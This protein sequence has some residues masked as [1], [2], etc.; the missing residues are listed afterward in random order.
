[1]PHPEERSPSTAS[2]RMSASSS[3]FETR[4][5]SRAPHHEGR[6]Q[7][8]FKKPLPLLHR[9]V[10]H[11]AEQKRLF[12]AGLRLYGP[13]TMDGRVPTFAFT[14]AG[15]DPTAIAAHLARRAINAWSGHFYAVEP[16]ARLGLTDAG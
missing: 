3:W 7:I 15:H 16:I 4:A 6:R 9:D 1:M 11:A 14:V 8:I 5:K 12:G 2:R 10:R 13:P